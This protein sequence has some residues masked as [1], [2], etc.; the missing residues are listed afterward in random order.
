MREVPQL[1]IKMW[2]LPS[3]VFNPQVH[4]GAGL[5]GCGVIKAKHIQKHS[6]IAPE[7]L[8]ARGHSSPHHSTFCQGKENTTCSH[9]GQ[10]EDVNK[11]NIVDAETKAGNLFFLVGVDVFKNKKHRL[12]IKKHT[13]IWQKDGYTAWLPQCNRFNSSQWPL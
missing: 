9:H 2:K 4:T 12:N 11:K 1:R 7:T 6:F 5:Q 3:L 10:E 8:R 13:Y